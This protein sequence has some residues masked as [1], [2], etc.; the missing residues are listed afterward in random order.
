MVYNL[1]TMGI[2][3]RI[4]TVKKPNGK[5]Y[6]YIQ[7]IETER[8]PRGPRQRV[9]ATLG[10][11]DLDGPRNV[12]RLMRNL[13]RYAERA[14][15]IDVLKDMNPIWAKRY[16][17][18]LV[19]DKLWSDLGLKAI[20]RRI[21]SS[22][23]NE[24]SFERAVFSMVY[25]R[26]ADP[27]SKLSLS[28]KLREE[29][30][31]PET[32]GLELQHLYRALDILHKNKERIEEKLFSGHT[33]LFSHQLELVFFDTTST[34]FEGSG[35]GS[36]LKR[37]GHSR[38]KRPD[39]KQLVIGVLMTGEGIP[40]ACRAFP[41]N[42]ADARTI[43]PILDDMRKRFN[44]K[45]VV[46][47]CDRGMVS[48]ANLRLMASAGYGYIVGAKMSTHEAK[49]AIAKATDYE[50]IK[51]KD[52]PELWVKEAVVN[53][54]RY[55]VCYNPEEAL[56]DKA[57]REEMV[58]RLEKL[59]LDDPKSLIR[60]KGFRQFVKLSERPRIDYDKLRE[61]EKYDGKYVIQ[62]SDPDMGTEEA[63]LAYRELWKIERA[64]RTLKSSLEVR[65]VYHWTDRRIEAHV[66]ACFLALVMARELELRLNKESEPD[67]K[68]LTAE[69]AIEVLGRVRAVAYRA[70]STRILARTE[71]S[72]DALAI[73]QRIGIKEPPVFI[74]VLD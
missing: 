12:D 3:T 47:V 22:G 39:R 49:E 23:D 35:K 8:T 59:L 27:G 26:L 68:R 13:S 61:A 70:G 15:M 60:N 21:G 18:V 54:T 53:G 44:I 51:R 30:Y 41:G 40:I 9:L 65:P 31:I 11:V 42:T 10:R 56:S 1:T 43:K 7:L 50:V 5:E 29:Y 16:G 66:F 20:L 37:F 19:A 17:D 24:F 71:L 28:E 25:D 74:Q 72:S 48:E 69:R 55:I 2:G 67:D 57:R 38:D 73:L 46:F 33:D 64:F 52:K 4:K 32:D 36:E 62:V 45:R 34:Y 63:T 58:A 14:R 6:S